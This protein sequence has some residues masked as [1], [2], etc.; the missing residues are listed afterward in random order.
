VCAGSHCVWEKRRARPWDAC[1]EGIESV[2]NHD[3]WIS[4][5]MHGGNR[6]CAGRSSHRSGL[7]PTGR[8]S[9]LTDLQLLHG[10]PISFLSSHIAAAL[11]FT[12]HR[13]AHGANACTSEAP[14]A[15]CSSPVGTR[16]CRCGSKVIRAGAG[17]LIHLPRT[18]T[19]D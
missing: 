11:R 3:R 9:A 6:I 10:K 7:R 1:M 17:R 2:R 15:A 12:G 8:R 16:A 4:G 5:C 19:M 13:A 14:E 18:C